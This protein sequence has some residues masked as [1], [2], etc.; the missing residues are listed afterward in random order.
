MGA[1]KV[2]FIY[3]HTAERKSLLFQDQDAPAA[4][5]KVVQPTVQI[6]LLLFQPAAENKNFFRARLLN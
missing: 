2:L 5:H 4:R 6:C 1:Q 3:G